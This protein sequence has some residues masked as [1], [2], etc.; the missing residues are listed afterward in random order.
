MRNDRGKAPFRSWSYHAP[1]VDWKTSGFGKRRA[2]VPVPIS[3]SV[4][5][6]GIACYLDLENVR[7]RN[8]EWQARLAPCRGCAKANKLN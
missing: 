2:I 1:V 5:D 8:A 7:W 3:M 6:N 4:I